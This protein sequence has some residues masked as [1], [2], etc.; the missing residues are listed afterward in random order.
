MMAEFDHEAR[1][2]RQAEAARQR[3]QEARELQEW[4]AAEAAA[5]ELTRE[6]NTALA[7][8]MEAH[9]YHNHR[10]QWRRRRASKG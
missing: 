9:G 10:G 3:E 5:R 2:D 8:F 7:G 6:S 1:M 4:R